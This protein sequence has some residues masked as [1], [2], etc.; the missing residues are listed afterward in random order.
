MNIWT[1][2]RS[3]A[4]KTPPERNRYVDFLRALS[5][6]FVIIGHWLLATFYFENNQITAGIILE[7]NPF[8]MWLTW[9]FQVMPIFFI[10]GGY[11]NA[12]SLESAQRKGITYAEWLYT[13]LNRLVKPLL[14]LVI[15]WAFLSFLLNVFGTREEL[16][17]FG[18]RAS[19]VPTWFLAI[20][21]II[22]VLAPWLWKLWKRYGFYSFLFFV[23]LAVITDLIFFNFELKGIGWSNYFW[24][25][26]SIHILGFA[27]RDKRLNN[28]GYTICGAIIGVISLYLLI[29]YGPYP[30]AMAGSPGESISNTLPPKITLIAL[31]IFQF[32]LLLSIEKPMQ[33]V[34]TD[35]KLW[36]TTVIINSMIMTVYLWHVT[37]MI[38]V[39]A[40]LYLI[41]GIGLTIEP[42]T[43]LWWNTRPLWIFTLCVFLLF[44]TLVFSRF[45]RPQRSN[46]LPS[47]LRLVFGAICICVGVAMLTM[48][49]LNGDP[50]K[51]IENVALLLV[52]LG[53]GS[54]SLLIKSKNS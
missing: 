18:S 32:G 22:A 9:G 51:G 4:E 35:A 8:S 16:I 19:F 46:T 14:L 26:F 24:V 6:L 5:I 28:T 47:T 42:G 27:W 11:S 23:L 15:F 3:L 29:F 31:G 2:A 25:W 37:A 30:L 40:L 48:L 20:Y 21:I 34:L 53:A 43:N 38:I 52:I 49:G 50:F 1:K 36:T 45:E 13:R 39:V 41:G 33:K 10:V 7:V 44:F 17:R 54:C 12:V